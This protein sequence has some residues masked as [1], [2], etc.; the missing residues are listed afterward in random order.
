VLLDHAAF[1]GTQ[2]NEAE[3]GL[4][5][6]AI[7][8]LEQAVRDAPENVSNARELDAARKGADRAVPAGR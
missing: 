5:A 8:Q 4:R 7:A 6:A 2:G 1:E 3:D